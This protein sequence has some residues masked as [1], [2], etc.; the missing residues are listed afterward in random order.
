MQHTYLP[1]SY[2]TTHL[3]K[4]ASELKPTKI[5]TDFLATYTLQ[6]QLMYFELFLATVEPL[7]WDTCVKGIGILGPKAPCLPSNNTC[8]ANNR[9][10]D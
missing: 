8:T 9:N 7:L 4:P 5:F 2:H 1:I 3:F 10:L 6:T